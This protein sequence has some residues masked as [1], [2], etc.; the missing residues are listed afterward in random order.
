MMGYAKHIG[1]VGALAVA[2]G[3]GSAVA[4]PQVASAEDAGGPASSSTADSRSASSPRGPHAT[5]VRTVRSAGAARVSDNADEVAPS[6]SAQTD[7]PT[8]DLDTEAGPVDPV[9]PEPGPV[10]DADADEADPEA[11]DVEFPASSAGGRD[12][13]PSTPQLRRTAPLSVSTARTA[14]P[15]FGMNTAPAAAAAPTAGS[16]AT[17]PGTAAAAADLPQVSVVVTTKPSQAR[18]PLRPVRNLVLGVL[19][20]FGFN[21]NPAPGTANNPILEGLWG[22]YRRIES[23]L[24]NETPTV[25]SAA[26]IDRSLTEDGR[27]AVTLDVVFDDYDGDVL[28]YTT[29]DG[30]HGTL[31]RNLDG[32]YTYLT[33]A[34][35]G[36]D[37]VS[38]TARDSGFHLHGL[39][40][41]FKPGGGHTSTA[42]LTLTLDATGQAPV[43]DGVIST[44]GR[45]NSWVVDVDARDPHGNPPTV[46]LGAGQ[47]DHVTVIRNADGRYTVTVTDI[48][49][50][51]ANPG[52]QVVV[53]ATATSVDENGKVHTASST[54]AIGTV[55]NFLAVGDSVHDR[56]PALPAGMTWVQAVGSGFTSVL[57]RSDGTAFAVGTPSPTGLPIVIPEL[58]AGLRYTQVAA[59]DGHVVLLRSDGAATSV[60]ISDGQAPVGDI[61]DLPTG[62][63]YTQVAAGANHTVLL[64]SDGTVIA[65][66]GRQ[67]GETAIPE[68]PAGASYTAISAAGYATVLL[69]SDGTAIAIGRGE[70]GQ[71]DVPAPP[72]GVTYTQ[73]VTGAHHTVLLHSDGTV[74]AFGYDHRGQLEIPDLPDGMTYTQIAAGHYHTLLMRSDGAVIALGYYVGDDNG[75][76][77]LPE[78]VAYSGMS[79]HRT[80]TLLLTQRV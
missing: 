5:A 47:S 32:T 43:I 58:P 10:A 6:E 77:T 28:S 9:D 30:A 56:A 22:A 4:G 60:D 79:A 53:T 23:T 18:P 40:G 12:R 44:P 51:R 26:V 62:L 34:T 8:K 13:Q 73:A 21:S 20:L 3:I 70:Y 16:T 71:N 2:L 64:R 42:S 19:G 61:P 52:T 67:F 59:G 63:V 41:M 69:R 57:L 74:T 50:A 39:L 54:L 17:V 55:S 37:T 78:G 75:I 76:P 7:T 29:T 36:T 24:F 27:L 25:K 38:I 65:I 1:R 35:A 80:A 31:T 33:D 49:W 66:G 14:V 15:S 68:L 45:G 11:V 72:P 46:A 48:G